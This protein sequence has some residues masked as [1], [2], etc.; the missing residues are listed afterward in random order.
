[1][2]CG[3]DRTSQIFEV[4]QDSGDASADL[5]VLVGLQL[6]EDRADV[7]ST[8]D[9]AVGVAGHAPDAHLHMLGPP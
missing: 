4:G 9:R 2:T 3:I 5:P 1:M 6:E 7:L 8:A